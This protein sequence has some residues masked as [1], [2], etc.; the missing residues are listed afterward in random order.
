MPDLKAAK[1]PSKRHLSREIR[2]GDHGLIQGLPDEES[3]RKV[4]GKWEDEF[5]GKNLK[6]KRLSG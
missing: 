1:Q 3:I 6:V 5:L 4:L 2:A